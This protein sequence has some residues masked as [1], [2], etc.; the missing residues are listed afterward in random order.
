MKNKLLKAVK[1]RKRKFIKNIF[2]KS[3]DWICLAE[4]GEIDLGN[5]NNQ[6]DYC[7]TDKTY[8]W[9]NEGSINIIN[10]FN[11]VRVR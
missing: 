11:N 9:Y 8:N 3:S 10:D 6:V 4:D 2:T 7:N 1:I 5:F